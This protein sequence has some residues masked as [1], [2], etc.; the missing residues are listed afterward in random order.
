MRD[1][2][3]L[4]ERL[5]LGSLNQSTCDAVLRAF[6]TEM[7]PRAAKMVLQAREASNHMEMA[8]TTGL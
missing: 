3:E 2:I 7:V 4:A 1:A 8:V 5:H 6:E